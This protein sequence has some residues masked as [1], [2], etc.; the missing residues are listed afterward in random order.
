MAAPPFDWYEYFRL[1]DELGQRTDEASLRSAISRAYYFVYHLALNRA[2]A[3]NFNLK[4]DEFTHAQ[5]WLLFSGNPEP[6]CQR[7]AV[8]ANRMKE[9]RVRA[10]YRPS[11][12]RIDEEVPTIIADAHVN[13]MGVSRPVDAQEDF[14]EVISEFPRWVK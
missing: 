1:A 3:N 13:G 10:D 11:F 7:L 8:I 4:L 5:L 14:T 2:Q 6:E 12:A 9:K